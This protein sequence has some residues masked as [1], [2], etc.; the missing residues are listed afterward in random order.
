VK[1]VLLYAAYTEQLSYLDDWVDAFKE[2]PQ[3]QAE[4]INVYHSDKELVSI[5]KK[6]ESAELVVLH[7]SMNGDTLKYLNPLISLLQNRKGKLVSFVGN[8]VNLPI[9]G[10]APKIKLLQKLEPDI[11]A[12]QLLQEAG[13]WL[14]ADCIKSKIIS[15]P[16]A[17]NPKA[18]FTTQALKDRKIDI[19]TRSARYSLH[20]GDDDRNAI[21]QF[22]HEN[23]SK[24]GLTVDFG[25]DKHSRQRFGRAEWA[26]F[27][28]SCKATISTEA[29][30]FYLEKNDHLVE[31]IQNFLRKK[32]K[33][34]VLPDAVGVRKVCRKI[35]PSFVRKLVIFML[36]M[37]FVEAE[38][39]GEEFGFNEVNEIKKYFFSKTQKCP[40]YSK[41]ISS[42]HFDAIGTKTL[43]IMYPGRYN[44]ILKP[45]EHYFELKRNHSNIEELMTFLKDYK[46]VSTITECAFDYVI[47]KHTHKDRL[48]T[49][50]NA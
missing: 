25:F 43:H 42:R 13:V 14:Y 8:E 1:T 47:S 28:N 18:F 46:Q 41:A 37:K 29:G 6:I 23:S 48:D 38:N 17:L 44:D 12:T 22:F 20:I 24:L 21:I 19:G 49:L 33:K 10:M 3:Y 5:R 15:L 39:L 11:I 30:S 32:T 45:G 7:H 50:L 16:H 40:V 34:I 2:H 31:A 27:L 4:C 9:L 26:S 36:K 35:L